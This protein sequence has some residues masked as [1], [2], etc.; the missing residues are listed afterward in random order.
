MC[1]V[2]SVKNFENSLTTVKV[3]KK[4]KV[5]P[6]YLGHG[7]Y[8]NTKCLRTKIPDS[9]VLAEGYA[10]YTV[11]FSFLFL[12]CQ[13]RLFTDNSIFFSFYSLC[14]SVLTVILLKLKCNEMIIFS[15]GNA[16]RQP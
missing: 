7:V 13:I 6:F 9:A 4:T 10:F 1:E 11:R 16:N 14:N 8:L 15:S 2:A 5:A 3:M 12:K